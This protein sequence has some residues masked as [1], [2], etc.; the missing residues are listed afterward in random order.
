LNLRK[1]A[2]ALAAVLCATAAAAAPV[3][4]ATATAARAAA[5]PSTAR[6]LLDVACA[7]AKNC[8]AVGID[9]NAFKGAGGPLA[10]RW[11]GTTWRTIAVK[12]PAG[13]TGGGLGRISCARA[14]HCVAVGFYDKGSGNQFALADTWN[15]STWTPA[16][17]PAPGGQNTALNGVSCKSVTRCVAVGTFTRNTSTGPAG[18]LLAESLNG[19]K[20]TQSRPP[21]PAGTVISGLN[22]VSCTSTTSCVATGILL[23]NTSSAALIESWNG[24]TWTRM[25]APTLP[26]ATLGE[27]ATVSCPSAKSCVAVGDQSSPKGLSSLTEI[28]NGKSWTAKLVAWPKGTSNELLHGVSCAAV[29]RCVATGTIDMNLQSASNTGRAA[30]VTWN[31][32]AWTVTSVPAPGKGKA[33]SFQGVTCLSAANCVTAG[34]L[35]PSGSTN[36]TGLSGFW[37]G[38]SW[39][40]LTAR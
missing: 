10:E 16:Q 32:T 8:L 20:W 15:G 12:L 39:R 23:T 34:Q 17:P 2:S 31:G 14:T 19:G 4:A 7:T 22:G 6:E 25:K 11:N 18:T 21:A 36:G 30:A 33:S 29:N 1:I 3:S 38:R 13:A 24:K 35:G 28:W 5:A 27:L 26:P 9:Q 37:N 40:L